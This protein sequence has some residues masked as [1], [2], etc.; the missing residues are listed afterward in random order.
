MSLS[1]QVISLDLAKHLKLLGVKQDA[2]F[3]YCIPEGGNDTNR[4]LSWKDSNSFCEQDTCSFNHDYIA[5]FTVAELGEMLPD[6]VKEGNV[7]HLQSRFSKLKEDQ[8]CVEYVNRDEYALHKYGK[9]EAEA[10]GLMLAYLIEN[11]LMS[12]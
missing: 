7:G 3:Y 9:T 1:Q 10:R 5:A 11:K 4:F 8:W 2:Q 6:F 12:V